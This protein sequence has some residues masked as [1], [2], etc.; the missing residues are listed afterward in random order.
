MRQLREE[1]P[2]ANV[3]RD[4]EH[5]YYDTVDADGK[6]VTV[7]TPV[8]ERMAIQLS[9]KELRHAYVEDIIRAELRHRSEYG[10]KN[11]YTILDLIRRGELQLHE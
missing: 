5:F 6:S 10:E 1:F 11:P 3:R 9:E 2:E 4:A 7:A 8:V